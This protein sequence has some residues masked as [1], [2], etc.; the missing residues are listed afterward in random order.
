MGVSNLSS[1]RMAWKQSLSCISFIVLLV[2]CNVSAKKKVGS[3]ANDPFLMRGGM[4][5]SNAGFIPDLLNLVLGQ[6]S[7]KFMR[8][9]DGKYGQYNANSNS[10]DGM[11]GMA[12]NGEVD[13]I[14]A[15]LTMTTKRHEALEFTVPFMSAQVTVLLKKEKRRGGRH[16]GG[17]NGRHKYKNVLEMLDNPNFLF[18]VVNGGSTYNLL[19]NSKIAYQKQIFQRMQGN[20]STCIVNSY[21]EAIQKL[22]ESDGHDLGLIAESPAAN[23]QKTKNCKLYSVGNLAEKY[24]G[25]AVKR[26]GSSSA[27]VKDLSKKILE[28]QESGM[29][30]VMIDTYF[31]NSKCHKKEKKLREQSSQSLPPWFRS[32]DLGGGGMG[33]TP[34]G[35]GI[36]VDK[37]YFGGE[38]TCN[39]MKLDVSDIKAAV[40]D[41]KR[42]MSDLKSRLNN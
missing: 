16:G 35:Y 3:I 8:P 20:A 30:P 24:Y 6:G 2:I 22:A 5:G 33:M 26:S 40:H 17:G 42:E 1:N 23:Y 7:Y 11:I 29:L 41:I 4:R 27:V 18:M 28:L 25:L 34:T 9:S 31:G 14:A 37:A 21:A 12:V 32:N 36:S 13:M 19:K 38:G 15:D 10:W 39:S